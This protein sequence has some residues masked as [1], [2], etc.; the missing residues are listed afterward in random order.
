MQCVWNQPPL[1]RALAKTG[2]LSAAETLIDTTPLD[3]YLCMRVRGQIAALRH[4][5]AASDRW[6]AEALHLAPS[7][8]FAETEWGEALL[9]RGDLDGAIARS[10]EMS[11]ADQQA[12]AS[13]H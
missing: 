11:D 6:F 5:E 8:P 9:A 1:A 10:L 13:L 7:L 4:D 12:I 2:D 3:C